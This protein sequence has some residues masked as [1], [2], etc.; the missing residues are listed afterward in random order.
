MRA[1]RRREH[2]GRGREPRTERE[3]Y[4]AFKGR[5]T[6]QP[7]WLAA[8]ARSVLDKKGPDCEKVAMLRALYD[9]GSPEATELLLLAVRTLPDRSTPQGESIPSFVV[10]L[11]SDHALG[12]ARARDVLHQIAFDREGAPLAGRRRAAARFVQFATPEERGALEPELA[13]EDD[14]VLIDG[15]VS[16]LRARPGERQAA[17]LVAR[18]ERETGAVPAESRQEEHE[19]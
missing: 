16:V 9:T 6:S 14:Q 4:Q 17:Y 7:G 13:R 18:F 1:L 15:V 3:F 10:S 19:E 11:M 12:D 2:R 8:Q 5:E